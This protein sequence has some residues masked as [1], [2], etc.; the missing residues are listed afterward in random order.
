M[1][2][3]LQLNNSK[4]E[5]TSSPDAFDWWAPYPW[6][7]CSPS[8][9]ASSHHFFSQLYP[10]SSGLRCHL[11]TKCLGLAFTNSLLSLTH[12]QKINSLFQGRALLWAFW[13][14]A[15]SGCGQAAPLW[16]GSC[17]HRC[18]HRAERDDLAQSYLPVIRSSLLYKQW[19]L[20]Y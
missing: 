15:W 2:D 17:L 4:E 16:D 3:G 19:L 8:E 5:A 7:A 20:W 13:F 14:S 10:R 12:R 6:R 9:G 18:R 1:P 11:E